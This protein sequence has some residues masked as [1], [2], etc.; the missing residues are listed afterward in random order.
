MKLLT[1]LWILVLLTSTSLAEPNATSI[2]IKNGK[3]RVAQSYCAMCAD[4]SSACRIAC[5]GS[6]T[7]IQACD[8]DYRN[9]TDQ[10][11]RRRY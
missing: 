10:N 11:C 6:G 7:C 8:D 2:E 9:R 4:K 1:A 3:F 5:N